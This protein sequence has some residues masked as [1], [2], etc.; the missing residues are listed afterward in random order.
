MLGT[1]EMGKLFATS[2][3]P[4][5]VLYLY[6]GILYKMYKSMNLQ[7]VL[8]VVHFALVVAIHMVACIDVR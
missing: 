4:M 3:V 6:R 8:M 1:A 2:V 5:T 7:L